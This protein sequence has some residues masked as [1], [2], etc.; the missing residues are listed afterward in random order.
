[1]NRKQQL[2]TDS[3]RSLYES[4]MELYEALDNAF[5][6]HH[7]RS[8]PL[9]ETFVDRWERAKK[10]GFGERSSIYDSSVVI[11]DV[12][13]GVNVWIGPFT[14]ID[15]SGKIAIGD[16]CTISAGVHIYTHDNVKQTLTSG[17][18]EIERAPVAVGKN[19]YV[20]PNAIIAKGVNIGDSCVIGANAFVN[21]D[22]PANSIVIGQ[23]AK[24]VG[25]VEFNDGK[26]IFVYSNK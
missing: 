20:G 2:T 8:L 9:N 7:N 18:M 26:P 24:V 3:Q 17:A 6:Q 4:I 10:L 15:G 22:V 16:Y 1:M 25:K 11:G 23:P 5:L 19:V 21:K 14:I 12:K 13:V